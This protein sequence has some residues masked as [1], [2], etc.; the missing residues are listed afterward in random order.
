MKTLSFLFLLGFGT[1]LFAQSNEITNTAVKINTISSPQIFYYFFFKDSIDENKTFDEIKKIDVDLVNL[2]DGSKI[3]GVSCIIGTNPINI[4]FKL[5]LKS[6]SPELV[7]R[8]FSKEYPSYLLVSGPLIIHM[9]DGKPD[10]IISP[11]RIKELTLSTKN[12]TDNQKQILINNSG[13]YT[14]EYRNN[15]SLSGSVGEEDSV[16]SEYILNFDIQKPFLNDV[17]GSSVFYRFRGRVSTNAQNP[18]NTIEAYLMYYLEKHFYIEAGR[19]GPQKFNVNSLRANIGYETLIPNLIDL[20]GGK[21]RLRLKPYINF[22]LAYQQNFQINNPFENK[23]G[24]L[25]LFAS[26]YYY[27]PVLDKFAI[28][29]ECEALYSYKLPPGNKFLFGYSLT[30]G[31]ETPLSDLKALFRVINGKNEVNIGEATTYSLGIL[32]DFIPF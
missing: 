27:V 20:T 14:P 28:I 29:G 30:F 2:T 18:L 23:E 12:L 17:I 3:D 11:D 22:G 15:I 24:N 16:Q 26:G 32:L 5:T 4:S 9:P 7:E 19:I 25:L 13:K 21:P 6:S 8:I 31:Y 10:F 1:G